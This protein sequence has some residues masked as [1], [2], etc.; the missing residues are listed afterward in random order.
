MIQQHEVQRLL[1]W[2]TLCSLSFFLPAI[3]GHPANAAEPGATA[4]LSSD[5]EQQLI[6][7][8]EAMNQRLRVLEETVAS[9]AADSQAPVWAVEGFAET[10]R[11]LER[12]ARHQERALAALEDPAP[13]LSEPMVLLSI[14][15][16]M[17]VLGFIGGRTLGNRRA[18]D[19]RGIL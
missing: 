14:G 19:R 10:D 16:C 7:A 17:L 11:R 13:R 4:E 8:V 5:H 15:L 1:V 6:E 2:A 9:Q 18:R 12:L 3:D